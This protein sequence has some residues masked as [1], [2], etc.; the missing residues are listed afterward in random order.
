MVNLE[1][2]DRG[3]MNLLGLFMEEILKTTLAT[4]KESHVRDIHGCI[5]IR[6]GGMLVYLD[7]DGTVWRLTRQRPD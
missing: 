7:V 1:V 2:V 6:G 3:R 5:E 4:A